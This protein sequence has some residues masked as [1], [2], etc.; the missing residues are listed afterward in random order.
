MANTATRLITL[1]MLLQRQPNRKGQELAQE[2]GVSVRTLQ[3]YIAML[4]EMGIPVYAERGPHGG[5]SLAR[6]YKMPPLILTSDEAVAVYLGT[7]LVEQMWGELYRDDAHG[8]LAKLDNILPEKQ[9][10]EVTRARRTL[11]ATHMH[12]TDYTSLEPIL[13]QLR[14]AALERRRVR[15]LYQGRSQ[16]GSIERE[17]EPYAL[18][19]RGGW[20]YFVGY[21]RLRSGRRLFRVDRVVKLALLEDVFDVPADF[22]I[23]EYLAIEPQT[24]PRILVRLRFM[25]VGAQLALD[26]RSYWDTLERQ[27]DGSVEVSFTVPNIEAAVCIVMGYSHKVVVVEPD[28]LRNVVCKRACAIAAHYMS[29]EKKGN[30]KGVIQ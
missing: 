11:I 12:R 8:A 1:I 27:E 10:N 9:C 17:V 14:R 18:V 5:Y 13:E 22:D 4:D 15:M 2:L 30:T 20:W 7:S 6:G 19:H 21:C 3:R 24:Q 23:K 26:D 29:A 25:A 16:P 28:E